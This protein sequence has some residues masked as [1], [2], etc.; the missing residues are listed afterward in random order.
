MSAILHYPDRNR[1]IDLMRGGAILVVI[2]SH[3]TWFFSDPQF[4]PGIVPSAWLE[5]LRLN[6]SLGVSMFFVLSGYLITDTVMERSG[7]LG[8]VRI[9]PF[10]SYRI[11]RLLPALL[12]LVALNLV[13][14]AL[15]VE[16]FAIPPAFPV[17]QVLG[18]V[19]TFRFNL[20]YLNGGALLLPW[21]VLWSL[22][23]EEVFYLGFPL[24][25]HLLRPTW[26]LVL[27]AVIFLQGPFFRQHHGWSGLYLYFG[28]FDQLA[29]G[30][31]IA[32]VG[33]R[34]IRTGWPEW[35]ARLFQ[36][37]GLLLLS[38]VYFG[39]DIHRDGNWIWLPTA[40]A[41]GTG[42]F[43]LGCARRKA[44]R[45]PFANV[46]R[47]LLLP[48][49]LAGFLSYEL[50]LFH[51]PAL[52]L[53]KPLLGAKVADATLNLPKDLIFP[54]VCAALVLMA[55]LLYRW[56]SQP[57]MRWLR[58]ALLPALAGESRPD[59]SKGIASPLL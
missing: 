14:A 9:L 37:G 43:I 50:Y 17:S 41:V 13:G 42:I 31:F 58:A 6:G 56:F 49:C 11:S 20:F 57:S 54:P 21:A 2:F 52:L 15:L 36:G 26:L 55:A 10:F 47:K 32:M 25:A 46:V 35:R 28:C 30:C 18:A 16:N 53:L 45:S 34:W 5:A 44:P 23:I 3:F 7:R 1:A 19:F 8:D 12:L 29:L 24:L 51:M 4:A 59:E 33:R 40:T 39:W 27:C 48:V 22:A 38:V